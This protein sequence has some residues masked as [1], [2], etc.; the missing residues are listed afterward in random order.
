MFNITS[1]KTVGDFVYT[2]VYAPECVQSVKS[3]QYVVIRTEENPVGLPICIAT[4]NKELGTIGFYVY[5]EAQDGG[6]SKYDVGQSYKGITGALGKPF[7]D[8][9]GNSIIVFDEAGLNTAISLAVGFKNSGK[10]T[11]GYYVGKAFI[12]EN[13]FNNF[14]YFAKVESASDINLEFSFD[15]GIGVVATDVNTME[16]VSGVLLNKNIKTYACFNSVILDGIGVCGGC[17]LK[18]DGKTVFACLS[19]PFFLADKV[20][21]KYAQKRSTLK[22]RNDECNLLVKVKYEGQ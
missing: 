9:D 17:R 4:A 10:K 16:A 8:F 12:E 19:G 6:I 18:V 2:E 13:V 7:S 20:D 11:A 21:F 15:V 3:G 1:K 5:K 22:N 14:D